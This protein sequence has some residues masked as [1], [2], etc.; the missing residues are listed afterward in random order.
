MKDI[1][2]DDIG[3]RF[4]DLEAEPP[5]TGWSE[6]NTELHPA[7]P[8]RTWFRK[9]GWKPLI[10]IIPV[11]SYVFYSNRK[12]GTL[13]SS[14][15]QSFAMNK[16]L[17]IVSGNADLD[18][19]N[20]ISKPQ[21]TEKTTPENK[22]KLNVLS[23]SGSIKKLARENIIKKTEL[24][25]ELK[26]SNETIAD[27]DERFE[28]KSIELRYQNN[29]SHNLMEDEAEQKVN[30]N[31]INSGKANKINSKIDSLVSEIE[32][33][34]QKIVTETHLEVS[35]SLSVIQIVE[36]RKSNSWRLTAS[37]T[38]NYLTNT[39]RPVVN[40]E[41]LITNIDKAASFQRIG[42]GFALGGGKEIASN[43][44][45]D[46]QLSFIEMQQS[47]SFT[48]TT[49]KIDTLLAVLQP[50]QNVLVTPVYETTRQE[51]MGKYRYAGIK[52]GVSYY[53]WATPKGRFNI[54][55]SAGTHYLFSSQVK[56]KME[57]QWIT[58]TN[59]DLNKVNYSGTIGAG[60]NFRF[61]E[62]E[63]M[64]NPTIN[65]FA[66]DVKSKELPYSLNNQ[67]L[68]LNFM[69]SKRVGIR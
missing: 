8:I 69:L 61:N 49:G 55:A 65:Y 6:I 57:G 37:V 47:P 68:G 20:E 3:K 52:L 31:G 18:S 36:K 44:F 26:G 38:A 63:L 16:R 62:W 41:V 54:M 14:S 40:D 10:I 23:G 48:Y 12:E 28:S 42:F 32:K 53:F 13:Q 35:D 11:S 1:D 59:K 43:L 5:T 9:N 60:Y 58:L 2:F 4:H 22:P 46:A 30:W 56:S 39:V 19:L 45:M 15:I 66:R 17:P 67:S 25:T 7:S 33:K 27:S 24:T 21:Y 50:D 29:T 64:I 34:E 51:I